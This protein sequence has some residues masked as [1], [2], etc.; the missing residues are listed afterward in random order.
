MKPVAKPSDDE[1]RGPG[2]PK[3]LR[4]II[5][6]EGFDP[7]AKWFEVKFQSPLGDIRSLFHFLCRP[8][9]RLCH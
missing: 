9:H 3:I 2:S 6:K 7:F 1:G 4:K 5:Q 8:Q